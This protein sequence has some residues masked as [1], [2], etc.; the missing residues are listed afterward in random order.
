[1]RHK[2]SQGSQL[3]LLLPGWQ[4]PAHACADSSCTLV[5]A[6]PDCQRWHHLRTVLRQQADG[7]DLGSLL[8]LEKVKDWWILYH[9]WI[10]E[11][12]SEGPWVPLLRLKLN[13]TYC[14]A[15]TVVGYV[16]SWVSNAGSRLVNRWAS[17]GCFALQSRDPLE[18][19]RRM[20]AELIQ[21]VFLVPG[22]LRGL[23]TALQPAQK[24]S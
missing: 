4:T 1:M 12:V 10:V 2:H 8:A 20:P 23:V 21:D 13:G 19:L 15:Q 11:G 3:I 24:T 22:S 6:D 16:R 18:A 5:S 14:R 17:W 9:P 7:V